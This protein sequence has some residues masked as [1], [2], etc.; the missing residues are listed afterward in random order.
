MLRVVEHGGLASDLPSL[1]TVD[2]E[3]VALMSS[4]VRSWLGT[5]CCCCRGD[6]RLLQRVSSR[7]T[8][9]RHPPALARCKGVRPELC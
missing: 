2:R 8:T 3:V 1:H 5:A 9:D 4:R 7:D 6:Q